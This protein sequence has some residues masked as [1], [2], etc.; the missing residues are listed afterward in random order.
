M[1]FKWLQVSTSRAALVHLTALMNGL[2]DIRMGRRLRATHTEFRTEF[3]Q[4][5]NFWEGLTPL[6]P[7]S[8]I[9]EH[10]KQNPFYRFVIGLIRVCK[11][12]PAGFRT[13]LIIKKVAFIKKALFKLF[14]AGDDS[15]S[16]STSSLNKKTGPQPSN[17]GP[18]SLTQKVN[19]STD[20]Q[21]KA[22]ETI[23]TIM[24]QRSKS[25]LKRRSRKRLID[26][27][28]AVP[29]MIFDFGWL[30]LTRTRQGRDG[31][32]IDT[33][34]QERNRNRIFF[35]WTPEWFENVPISLHADSRAH[36]S[37]S[38]TQNSRR[39]QSIGHAVRAGCCTRFH[40]SSRTPCHLCQFT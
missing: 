31:G 20:H 17:D 9:T 21:L 14:K 8:L 15:K 23:Y 18:L 28:A 25:Q 10:F 32:N 6:Q 5:N 26:L 33:A 22:I 1:N 12:I 4:L 11:Q 29:N 7:L 30:T 40:T 38:R 37:A 13:G 16:L 39:L 3:W 35:A 19:S 2:N 27:Q 24:R 36:F 34:L